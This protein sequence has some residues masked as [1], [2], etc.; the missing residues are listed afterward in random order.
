MARTR[1]IGFLVGFLRF[2]LVL[3]IILAVILAVAY[4]TTPATFGL[5]DK[6]INGSTL[7]E[8]GIADMRFTDIALM[9]IKLINEPKEKDMVDQSSAPKEE[10]YTSVSEK[11]SDS[12]KSGGA[13]T[14]IDFGALLS[15]KLSYE[16]E[17]KVELTNAELTAL[18]NLAF[19]SFESKSGDKRFDGVT[20]ATIE[21]E[22]LSPE[23][24]EDL[25]ISMFKFF[26]SEFKSVTPTIVG[27]KIRIETV[28]T[29]LVP[30][31]YREALGSLNINIAEKIYIR[32]SNLYK[33]VDGQFVQV[34]DSSDYLYFNN[35]NQTQSDGLIAIVFS[36]LGITGYNASAMRQT[37]DDTLG[38]VLALIPNNLGRVD[39][40]GN[41]NTTITLGA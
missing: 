2:L 23:I 12:S 13:A 40:S 15:G 6:S 24:S 7:S 26:Q 18:F 36:N 22:Q 11:T 25:V 3:I 41:G 5:A 31:E 10:D 33:I 38:N 16:G 21:D 17:K 20:A 9:A 8:M 30:T 27:D 32:F 1:K 29:F 34:D 35:M 37:Y 39:N 19:G 28:A 4:F 14:E